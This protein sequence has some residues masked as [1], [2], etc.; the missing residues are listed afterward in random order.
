[1]NS[2][3]P[4]SKSAIVEAIQALVPPGSPEPQDPQ[5]IAA[6]Q[7]LTVKLVEAYQADG[8]LQADPFEEVWERGIYLYEAEV[9]DRLAG[10]TV[11]V[12]GGEGCV[13][14]ALIQKLVQLGAGK[15]VSVDKARCSTG[16]E[17]E[18][19]IATQIPVIY[20]AVDIRDLTELNQVFQAEKPEIVFHLA[21]QRL[22]W[23]A[24]R[25][26]RETVTSNIFGSQ[27]IIELCERHHV[28]QCIYSSTGKASRYF[29][30]EVYAA[31]KKMSEWQFAQ[32][33]QSG[34]TAYGMVR[35]T[36]MLDNSSFCEYFDNKLQ[37]NKIVKVH[38]PHRYIVGQ[39][40]G[41]AMHLLLNALV[42]SQPDH[43]KFF[44]C[45]NLGWPVE[46]L[47]VA[48]H[49]IL[50]SG[51]KIPLYFQGLIAGYEEP[52]F[53]GQV[54]WSKPTQI[55]TL[56]SVIEDQWRSID[57]SGDMIVSTVAPFSQAALAKHLLLLRSLSDN[58]QT[59]EAEIKQS[60]ADATKEIAASTFAQTPPDVL[61]KIWK[62]G[63]DVNH[64][65]AGQAIDAYHQD[66]IDLLLGG[67]FKGLNR[68]DDL[69]ACMNAIAPYLKREAKRTSTIEM[70]ASIR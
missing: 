64:W 21:A 46:T 53:R 31:S 30:T 51:K 66:L 2:F 5:T 37:Q 39:N 1:M 48:L 32:A 68:L 45:R 13:G 70:T 49:K 25:E 29:T 56:I 59:V 27:N 22:P 3:S 23:L 57:S 50:H 7:E 14:Q 24:E 18:T 44:L 28:Q 35:F 20:Y 33:A 8:M 61:L 17:T 15:I 38:A 67:L 63:F 6:L 10:K 11:L 47:E 54:D 4:L 26:I 62:W 41:E 34:Q 36:H 69:S 40:V 52:F 12:T 42:L 58:P 60:L 55:N 16:A 43:L 9:R 65:T 19:A